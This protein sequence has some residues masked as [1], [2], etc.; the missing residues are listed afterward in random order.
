VR[1][2]YGEAASGSGDGL[3]QSRSMA[4]KVEQK[5]DEKDC[6]TVLALIRRSRRCPGSSCNGTTR[7]SGTW[8]N[9]VDAHGRKSHVT[10]MESSHIEVIMSQLTIA[11]ARL[12]THCSVPF[13]NMSS[14]RRL[15]PLH[16]NN[17]SRVRTRVAARM[18]E[19]EEMAQK[20]G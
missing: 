12:C 6:I 17:H 16:R 13:I 10:S 5:I 8:N 2:T 18:A 11:H 3:E 9:N 19:T 1:Q 20:I 4:A 14:S 7:W 15:Q